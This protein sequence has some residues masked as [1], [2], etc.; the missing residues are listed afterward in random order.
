[1]AKRPV[2]SVVVSAIDRI[3]APMQKINRSIQKLSRPIRIVNRS[4]RN[5]NKAAGLDKFI[6]SL[7]SART[8][9]GNVASS[10]GGVLKK[11]GLITGV[12][13][14]AGIAL[15][16]SFATAGDKIDK[17][18]RRLGFGSQA[19]QEWQHVAELNG[20][21][22]DLFNNSLSAF[23]KRLGEAKAGTGGL[24]TL[25][26]K[27]SPALLE[28][29]KSANS[30][31]AAFNLYI[32]AV[33]KVTDESKKAALTSAAFS[34][35]G[36]PLTNIM[37][38]GA[39]AIAHQR[40]EKRRLGLIDN[41]GIKSAAD[42]KDQMFQL[43]EAFAGVRNVVV[44]QVLPVFNVLI[45]RLTSLIV[46]MRPQIEQWAKGF[47]QNLPQRLQK[48]WQ[49]FKQMLDAIK[50]LITF[51]RWLI[52]N[53]GLMNAA[54]GALAV[55]IGGSLVSALWSAVLVIKALGLAILATPV[56]W[57]LAAIAAIAAA[58]FLIIKNWEPIKTFFIKLWDGITD[59]FFSRVQNI[60]GFFKGLWDGVSQLFDN[61]IKT[62]KDKL[63]SMTDIL[64]DFV[65]EQ[66]GLDA[67]ITPSLNANQIG[68]QLN[69]SQ[70]R[71]ESSIKVQFE[72]APKGTRVDALSDNNTDVNLDLGFSMITP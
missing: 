6:R 3:T 20:V 12:A 72:N 65:K 53:V 28:Q 62:L 43:S 19:L 48:I 47:A 4:L 26:K 63:L 67:S 1:M 35:A 54:F 46:K 37:N 21:S 18:A 25:L 17:T 30:V 60:K 33:G 52:Q 51:G 27:V 58:V 40:E 36:L 15:I 16:N 11:L 50:P 24:T 44:G 56:G 70:Q 55:I 41:A 29:L 59:T 10:I 7:K 8:H 9:A 64:P 13:G 69:A 57:I 32:N 39:N 71:S 68:S 22:Q 45:G 31:E 42:Y 5:L 38:A 14:G 61:G 49:G 34:R 66:L 23:G 2:L